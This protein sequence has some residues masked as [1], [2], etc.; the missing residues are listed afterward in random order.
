VVSWAE[1]GGGDLG[2]VDAGDVFDATGGQAQ[3]KANVFSSDWE[4]TARRVHVTGG[5]WFWDLPLRTESRAS[6]GQAKHGV[7]ASRWVIFH[8]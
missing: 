5:S 6:F 3:D 8:L 4:E 2:V 7:R 1:A